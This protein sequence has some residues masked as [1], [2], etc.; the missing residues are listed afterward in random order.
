MPVPPLQQ[1]LLNQKCLLMQILEFYRSVTISHNLKFEDMVCTGQQSDIV[2]VLCMSLKLI[3][4]VICI[5]PERLTQ[6]QF[7]QRE[8]LHQTKLLCCGSAFL[9]HAGAPKLRAFETGFQSGIF[10]TATVCPAV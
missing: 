9:L 10:E 6:G 1:L 8:F 7:T 4:C 3:I 5:R 2:G